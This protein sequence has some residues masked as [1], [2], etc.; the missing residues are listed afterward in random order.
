ML[1]P[2]Y[3]YLYVESV[4]KIITDQLKTHF[5]STEIAAKTVLWVSAETTPKLWFTILAVTETET[6]TEGIYPA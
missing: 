2:I 4:M 5:F 3:E 1:N 6:E